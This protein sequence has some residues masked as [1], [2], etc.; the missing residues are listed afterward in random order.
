MQSDYWSILVQAVQNYVRCAFNDE[1]IAI[2]LHLSRSGDSRHPIP[3]SNPIE[4]SVYKPGDEG[5]E[6]DNAPEICQE[7]EQDEDG[8]PSDCRHSTDFRHLVWF[9]VE[10]HFSPL[11]ATVIAE[12]WR[13]KFDLGVADVRQDVLLRKAGSDSPRLGD[14]FRRSPA[15][16]TAIVSRSPG[17]Y[18][19]CDREEMTDPD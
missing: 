12:L 13:A 3:V 4:I 19:L 5:S 6:A 16:G 10:L 17:S 8:I 1:P 14:L 15:F 2:T 18:R 11:Q 9:G 7:V